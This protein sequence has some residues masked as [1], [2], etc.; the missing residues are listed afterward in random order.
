MNE[1]DLVLYEARK[2]VVDTFQKVE[3][4]MKVAMEGHQEVFSGK[5][6]AG[7]VFANVSSASTTYGMDKFNTPRGHGFAAERANHLFDI[8]TGKTAA[9]Q[10]DDN[11]PGGADR[12]VNGVEIQS[13]Y[14]S[15]GSKCISECFE[16]GKFRYI[17]KDG[18]PMK[19]EVPSD[20][21]DAAVQAME[22]RIKNGEV[23]GV[24]DP[25][26]AKNIVKKGHFTYEQA[27]NIAKFGTVESLTYDAVN[28]AI[29][30]GSALGI[31]AIL[32]F[33]SSVWSGEDL[34][35]AL[36]HAAYS[37]L[38]VGGI[39]FVTS[40]LSS[41]LARTGLNSTL[42]GSTDYVVKAMG[43]KVSAHIANALRSGKNIYGAAAMNNVSKML[44][45]NM[46]T[47]A[48]SVAVLSSVDVI[49]IFRGRVSG[50]QLFKNLANT[51]TSVAGGTAG[52]V[53]GAAV[54]ATVGSII[55]VVGTTIGGFVGGFLGAFAGGSAAG[56]VSGAVLDAFIEDDAEEMVRIIEKVFSEMAVD[57]LLNQK[58]AEQAIDSMKNDLSGGTLK[59]MFAS[60]NR[61][62]FAE[63]FIRKHIETVVKK[64]QYIQVPN[65]H[66]VI[67]TIKDVL[68]DMID[69]NGDLLGGTV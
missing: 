30:A 62:K 13:K 37:G 69:N 23:P 66:A 6:T 31:T 17:A 57:Y 5:E 19:I 42:R 18:T 54:G 50:K 9:I 26:E 68:E 36:K 16:D 32:T 29:I 61:K 4:K 33:A 40:V 60:S 44:R 20:K 55:P 38:K 51:A 56:K 3:K 39:S 48:V 41:Q 35:I 49:N 1:K 65:D 64:R 15:T 52:W 2:T 8:V 22:N 45:G 12:L 63:K 25:K 10:G 28:G 43:P 46:I 7:V 67:K 59:D 47:A 53:G 24:T 11:A 34:D 27:K 21:Y 14:C 58:E